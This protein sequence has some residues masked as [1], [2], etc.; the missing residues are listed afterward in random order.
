MDMELKG[1]IVLP[2]DYLWDGKVSKGKEMV[3]YEKGGKVYAS[4]VGLVKDKRMTPLEM[5]YIPKPDDPIV[6]IIVGKRG[7]G[8]F[9]E[10]GTGYQFLI[11]SRTTRVRFPLGALVYGKVERVEGDGTAI[12]G[13]IKLLKTGKIFAISPSKVPRVIGKKA[14]M[15]NLIREKT[16]C[17]LYVGANGYVYIRGKK[18][19]KVIEAVKKI[20]NEAQFEG[21]TDRMTR[22]LGGE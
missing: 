18:I 8:Y 22:F 15:L 2:G 11:L 5:V 1:K 20:A 14:S 12:L 13:D 21:L 16:K 6:G 19:S 9:V 7:P 10:T 17:E 4:V 3:M